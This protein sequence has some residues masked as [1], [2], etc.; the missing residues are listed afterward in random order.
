MFNLARFITRLISE[1]ISCHLKTFER[2]RALDDYGHAM[3]RFE[4]G[5]LDTISYSQVSHGHENDLSI[6]IDGTKGTI[7]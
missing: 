6:Q 7:Q 5:A 3:I 1:S 4:N 2:G